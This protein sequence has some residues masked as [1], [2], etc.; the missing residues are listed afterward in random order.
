MK[1]AKTRKTIN[2]KQVYVRLAALRLNRAMFDAARLVVR[3]LES[4]DGQTN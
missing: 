1:Q 4:Q 2:G 3:Q